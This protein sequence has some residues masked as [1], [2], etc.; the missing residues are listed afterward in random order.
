MK[1]YKDLPLDIINFIL[2]ILL[3]LCVGIVLILGIILLQ[4][5]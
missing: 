5:I 4:V 3:A 2:M 1:I